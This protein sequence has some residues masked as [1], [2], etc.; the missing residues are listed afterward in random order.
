MHTGD[1]YR[2]L[3][4]FVKLGVM[5]LTDAKLKKFIITEEGLEIIKFAPDI[6]NIHC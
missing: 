1:V 2:A 6:F 5:A 4:R 3:Y